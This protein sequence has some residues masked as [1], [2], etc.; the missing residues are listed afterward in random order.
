MS[1]EWSRVITEPRINERIRVP[2][3]RLVGP[4]GEQVG[5]VRVEDALRLAQ[6]ADLDLVEVA[7]EA[8]PPVA[9]LMDYGKYKYEMAQKERA[10]RRNQ[11]NTQ[12]KEVQFRLKIDDHDFETKRGHVVRFLNGGDKVKVVIMFRGREQSRPELG[13]KLL[14]RLAESVTEYGTV[15]ARPRIDGRRMNM[16]LAPLRKKSEAIN[17]VRKRR[18]EARDERRARRQERSER[19]GQAQAEKAK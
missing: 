12:M 5:V 7:P 8:R 18:E 17:E 10:A 3:V 16:V 1:R 11:A 14:E 2:E 15:E 6:E 19:S 9:K 4:A 13:V